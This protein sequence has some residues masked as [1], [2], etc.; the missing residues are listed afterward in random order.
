M[1]S[2]AP[3]IIGAIGLY[4]GFAMGIIVGIWCGA[5]RRRKL[6]QHVDDLE[7]ALGVPVREACS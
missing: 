5:R 1:P 7:S 4:V 2:L 3:F 6:E